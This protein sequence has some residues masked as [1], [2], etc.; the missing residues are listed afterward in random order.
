MSARAQTMDLVK[1]LRKQGFDV[2][3]TGS[4]HWKVTNPKQGGHVIMGFS[5]NQGGNHKTLKRLAAIGY[6]P[7]GK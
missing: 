6:K 3:R 7:G 5:P 1:D 4:G 2:V